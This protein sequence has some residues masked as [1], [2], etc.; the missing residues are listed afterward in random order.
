MRKNIAFEEGFA[1]IELRCHAGEIVCFQG[2]QVPGVSLS[3]YLGRLIDTA[4]GPIDC[5]GGRRVLENVRIQI[6]ISKIG[7]LDF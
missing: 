7:K 2:E 3:E 4:A 1:S 6:R 5:K